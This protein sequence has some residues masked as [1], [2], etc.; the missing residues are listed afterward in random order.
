MCFFFHH[1]SKMNSCCA[2]F[3][4]D[5]DCGYTIVNIGLPKASGQ[6]EFL[7]KGV[8]L[9]HLTQDA[10]QSAVL[11]R[12]GFQVDYFNYICK[13]NGFPSLQNFA[14]KTNLLSGSMLNHFYTHLHS[15]AKFLA[16]RYLKKSSF[17]C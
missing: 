11:P 2:L 1:W 17:K 15:M 12:L 8:F 10:E 14:Q 4:D 16:A 9:F 7:S 6:S 3:S 13:L 5:C